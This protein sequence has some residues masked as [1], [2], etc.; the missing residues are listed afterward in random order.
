MTP[1]RQ[2]RY[3]YEDYLR[4]LD[5]SE[6][7]LEYSQGV[8]YA[9]AGGTPA[10]GQ[11]SV[12]ASSLLR[13]ALKGACAVFSSDVKVRVE[14][15]D[16]A[17]FPDVSVVCGERQASRVDAN[18]ITNPSILVEV[19]SRSTEAYDRGEK[20][21]HYQALPSLQAVLF[22]SHREK[23][24]TVVERHE[25]QWKEREVTSG[26]VTLRAPAVSFLLDELYAGVT[27]EQ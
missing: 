6:I 3:S 23:R 9:M 24:V 16:F 27:L 2:L 17:A 8:I 21:G 14:V 13:Q 5:D 11:L 20:L 7:K 26:Q 15:S 19:T 10:H 25:G 22:V 12:G 4:A 18:A 1:A